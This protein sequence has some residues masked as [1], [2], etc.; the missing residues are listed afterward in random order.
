MK[1]F[2]LIL[3]AGLVSI[4]LNS[5]KSDSIGVK[6]DPFIEKDQF[7]DLIYDINLLEGGLSNFNIERSSVT[8]S[9]M[10]LYKGILAKH[11]VDY[12]TFKANQEFYVLMDK[13]KEVSEEVLARIVEKEREYEDIKPI[14]IISFIQLSELLEGDK[15][16]E[17]FEKDTNTTYTQR[18]DSAMYFYRKR[19]Y[20][21]ESIDLDS[22]SFEVNIRKFKKGADLFR[23]EKAAFKKMPTN[24]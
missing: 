18:L 21:L 13:Y 20:R 12:T 7:V 23:L 17:F 5:C 24:E 11:E 14:K 9:A 6:P 3:Y 15:L 1:K 10:T 16:I 8:D 19:Q 4:F 22:I 2:S